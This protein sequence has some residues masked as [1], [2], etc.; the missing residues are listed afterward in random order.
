MGGTYDSVYIIDKISTNQR[1]IIFDKYL[2][3]G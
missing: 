2:L 3:K 1:I